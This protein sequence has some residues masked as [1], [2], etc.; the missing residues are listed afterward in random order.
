MQTPEEN[1]ASPTA[2]PPTPAA[3]AASSPTSGKSVAGAKAP[4]GETRA[5]AGSSAA[6]NQGKPGQTPKTGK[7]PELPSDPEADAVDLLKADHRRVE[8]LFAE[9][10]SAPDRRK[11]AIIQEACTE[12]TLH[13]LLEEEIFYPACR[14]ADGQETEDALDEARSSTIAPSSSSSNCWRAARK[15][16][17]RPP[18]SRSSPSRSNTMSLRRRRPG[19]A[20]SPRRSQPASTQP[21]WAADFWNGSVGC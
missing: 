21:R 4:P 16:R 7:A 15:I 8:A 13:T 11:A 9:F 2:K 3:A 12:L 1:A 17:S 18:G 5:E 10:E 14:A 20:S 19:R 6:A